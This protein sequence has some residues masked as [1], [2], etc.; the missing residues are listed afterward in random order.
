M[1]LRWLRVWVGLVLGAAGALMVAA[2]WQRWTRWCLSDT[3]VPLTGCAGREDHLYDF[4]PPAEPW[5]PVGTSAELGGASLLVLALVVPL[6]PWALTGRRPGVLSAVALVAAVTGLVAVGMA[7]LQSGLSGEVV[8]P[9]LGGWSTWAW[10][11]VLPSLLVHF[12][13]ASAGWA[14]AASVVLVLSTPLVAAFSYAVGEYD[15]RP[16]WEANSGALMVTAGLC[17][18]AAAAWP[19]R[20]CPANQQPLEVAATS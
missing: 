10:L 15:A 4:L 11:L 8:D 16:W 20:T 7:T 3:G 14:R 17:L 13:V 6:L 2:S 19:G 1:S 5:E 12:S 18:F 9:W